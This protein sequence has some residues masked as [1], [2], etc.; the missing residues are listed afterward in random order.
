VGLFAGLLWMANKRAD[1]AA[2]SHEP[3]EHRAK[4]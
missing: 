3:E 2:E 4:D 1:A